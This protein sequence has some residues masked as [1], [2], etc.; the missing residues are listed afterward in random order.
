MKNKKLISALALCTM[1]ATGK[2][3]GKKNSNILMYAAVEKPD[4][5]YTDTKGKKII[6]LPE[7]I[8]TVI[9]EQNGYEDVPKDAS[10]ATRLK[11]LKTAMDKG[12]WSLNTNYDPEKKKNSALHYAARK[13]YTTIIDELRRRGTDPN[14]KNTDKR[15]PLHIAGVHGW[16][17]SVTAIR[18]DKTADL[19]A[20]DKWGY[21][22]LHIASLYGR[23]DV[24]KAL[25]DEGADQNAKDNNDLTPLHLAAIAYGNFTKEKYA[26]GKESKLSPE[27]Q[28]KKA[29]DVVEIIKALIKKGANPNERCKNLKKAPALGGIMALLKK[30]KD[31]GFG[32]TPLHFCA[33]MGLDGAAKALIE[34]GAD[35]NLAS[36]TSGKYK[37]RRR[38]F[39]IAAIHGWVNVGRLLL[40]NAA[41]NFP[42]NYS[43]F[44]CCPKDHSQ[45][46]KDGSE[47]CKYCY[48]RNPFCEDSVIK[49]F[50]IESIEKLVTV[51]FKDPRLVSG[52]R[53]KSVR[54]WDL[55]TDKSLATFTGD[56]QIFAVAFAH[57][58]S[59]VASGGMNRNVDVWDLKT[60]AKKS[61][62]GHG[63]A[64]NT[65]SFS[66]DN[67]HIASGDAHGKLMVWESDGDGK[68]IIKEGKGIKSVQYDPAGTYLACAFKDKA[69]KI[70]D[71]AS[72]KLQQTLAGHGDTVYTVAFSPDGKLLASGS[73]DKT[74]KI[75]VTAS[76]NWKDATIRKTLKGHPAEI[77]GVAFSPTGDKVASGDENGTLNIW[78]ATADPKKDKA[79]K[80]INAGVKLRA[81]A[82][83]PDGKNVVSAGK[84]NAINIWNI[85]TGESI[86]TLTGN[87]AEINAIVTGAIKT[88]ATT[89]PG[90]PTTKKFPSFKEA[91][92]KTAEEAKEAGKKMLERL[93]KKAAAS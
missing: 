47:K 52:S 45:A 65:V 70:Y 68:T 46:I 67:E 44:G 69:I 34:G 90:A 78:D 57:D 66:P 22:P 7:Y 43:K 38:P 12:A 87:T 51:G 16:G 32:W 77:F 56:N 61:F 54:I 20:K 10:E 92:E 36:K 75:W 58:Q 62:K 6:G 88:E 72:W 15:T 76:G 4:K 23:K 63:A 93:K 26:T 29:A 27:Q 41:K 50:L 5:T 21:T 55:E 40:E 13:G 33:R 91:L 74:V 37:N 35:V 53:D 48:Y 24:V 86:K 3:S 30:G 31:S 80:T 81:V 64:I 59:R 17:K 14:F 79:L 83:T 11:I 73:R 71:T 28:K 19:E 39:H 18:K 8:E 25:L 85:E 42:D 1:L 49:K 89:A 60:K 84:N 2:I 9:K 82:F